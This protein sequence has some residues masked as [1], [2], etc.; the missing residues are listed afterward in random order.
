[1]YCHPVVNYTIKQEKKIE[2]QN[3]QF[4]YKRMYST[5]LIQNQL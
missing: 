1:M 5:S 3:K 4:L 2:E